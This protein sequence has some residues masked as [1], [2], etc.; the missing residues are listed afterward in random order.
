MKP[1]FGNQKNVGI[2][3]FL[4]LKDYDHEVDLLFDFFHESNLSTIIITVSNE[5]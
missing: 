2:F 3:R 4:M 5:N 1:D